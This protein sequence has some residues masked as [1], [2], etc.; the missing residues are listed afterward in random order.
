MSNEQPLPVDPAPVAPEE[1]TEPTPEELLESPED[2]VEVPEEQFVETPPALEEAGEETIVKEKTILEEAEGIEEPE[3]TQEEDTDPFTLENIQEQVTEKFDPAKEDFEER[4]FDID[5]EGVYPK[6]KE[7][8]PWHLKWNIHVGLLEAFADQGLIRSPFEQFAELRDRIPEEAYQYLD[9]QD[10]VILEGAFTLNDAARGG[11]KAGLENF[12]TGIDIFNYLTNKNLSTFDTDAMFGVP[13]DTLGAVAE[14]FG[15]F[16]TLFLPWMG[17]GRAVRGA[18]GLK[19]TL[20]SSIAIDAFASVMASSTGFDPEKGGVFTMVEQA[21]NNGTLP[22]SQFLTAAAQVFDS[23]QYEG[24]DRIKGRIALGFEDAL[25]TPFFELLRVPGAVIGKGKKFVASKEVR[26][27]TK[28]AIEQIRA[29]NARA[30]E[31]LQEN[32]NMSES[33]L[34][35]QLQMEGLG[36]NQIQDNYILPAFTK[37]ASEAFNIPTEQAEMIV[38]KFVGGGLDPERVFFGNGN[39]SPGAQQVMLNQ[40]TAGKRFRDED[41]FRD[42]AK[43]IDLSNANRKFGPGKLNPSIRE[44]INKLKLNKQDTAD[45]QQSVSSVLQ[46][47]PKGKDG[48]WE[49]LEVQSV[50]L[51]KDSKG[52]VKKNPKTGLPEVDV[53]FKQIPYTFNRDKSGKPFKIG[54]PEA[55]RRKKQLAKKMVAELKELKA[56]ANAGDQRAKDILNARTWYSGMEERL[57]REWGG[58]VD[59]FGEMLG[60]TSPQTPVAQ[61]Y[62]NAQQIIENFTK[63]RY[64]DVLSRYVA[65]LEN[66]G[67]HQTWID[68]GGEIIGKI[69]PK[70]GKPDIGPKELFAPQFDNN[71]KPIRKTVGDPGLYGTNTRNIMEVLA[72]KWWEGKFGKP[73]GAPKALTFAGNL[74]GYT[75][76]ATIDVWAARQLQRLSGKKMVPPPAEGAV[77]GQFLKSGKP[78]GAYGFASDVLDDAVE[79]LRK[80]GG[81]FEN[82]DPRDL[83]AIMW[84]Q[85]KAL[86]ADQGLGSLGGSMESLA[87]MFNAQRYVIGS[88]VARE[89]RP[90]GSR[91]ILSTGPDGKPMNFTITGQDR[92]LFEKAK[93]FVELEARNDDT[94]GAVSF[95][96]N[97][98]IF[99]LKGEDSFHLEVTTKNVVGR[100]E[101][102]DPATGKKRID[103]ATGKPVTKSVFQIE[104]RP[105]AGSVV[106]M[107]SYVG[108][109]GDQDAVMVSRVLPAGNLDETLEQVPNARPGLEMYFDK[110]V[111]VQEATVVLNRLKE[112]GLGAQTINEVSR[113]TTRAGSN[114][115]IGIRAVY[116]PEFDPMA[117]SFVGNKEGALAHVKGQ[118]ERFD[119]LAD[120]FDGYTVSEQGV[121]FNRVDVSAFDTKILG[122]EDYDR[123]LEEIN[124]GTPVRSVDREAWPQRSWHD[125]IEE[126]TGRSE[127]GAKQPGDGEISNPRSGSSPRELNQAASNADTPRGRAVLD[128]LS[129]VAFINGLEAA[130]VS[131][132]VHEF[133]HALNAQLIADD[134]VLAKELADFYGVKD[135]KWTDEAYERF[136]EDSE[137]FMSEAFEG[138]PGPLGEIAA[139]IRDIYVSSRGTPLEKR[140]KPEVKQFFENLL[141][142]NDLPIQYLPGKYMAPIS[143]TPL[144]K[145]VK[146]LEELGEDWRETITPDMIL[147]TAR[148]KKT[149][150]IN[151]ALDPDESQTLFNADDADDVHK[152][153]AAFEHF[154]VTLRKEKLMSN[155]FEDA[156]NKDA[157]DLYNMLLG[158]EDDQLH[159]TFAELMTT[160]ARVDGSG[161]ARTVAVNMAL[162]M[163]LEKVHRLALKAD[164]TGSIVDHAKLQRAFMDF[165]YVSHMVAMKKRSDGQSL[166]AWNQPVNMPTDEDLSDP[167]KALDFMNKLKLDPLSNQQIINFIKQGGDPKSHEGLKALRDASKIA[168]FGNKSQGQGRAATQEFF[169]N[170]LLSNPETALGISFLSPLLTLTLDGA[171]KFVGA[172]L[173]ADARTMNEVLV[174]LKQN[175]QNLHISMY[176]AMRTAKNEV[177][178]LMPGRELNDAN[179]DQRAIRMDAE[180]PLDPRHVVNGIGQVVRTPSRAIMTIDEL[181]RQTSARSAAYTKSYRD[182]VD[183]YI[184]VG[185][186]EGRIPMQLSR[187]GEMRYQNEIHRTAHQHALKETKEVIKDGRLQDQ[188]AIM[189]KVMNSPEAQALQDKPHE[190][191]LYIMQKTQEMYTPRQHELVEHAK[192]AAV[193]PVFQGDIGPNA[194]RFQKFLDNTSWGIGRLFVPFFRT[195]V[196]VMG[197]FLQY[198]PTALAESAFHTAATVATGGRRLAEGGRSFKLENSPLY[199]Y[200]TKHLERVNSADPVIRAEALGQQTVGLGLLMFNYDLYQ[201]GIIT[202]NGPN[203]PTERKILMQTGWQPYSVK[204]GDTYYSISRLDPYGMF[205]GM[206][207]D[208]FDL[209]ESEPDIPEDEQNNMFT[210]LLYTTMSQIEKMPML[211]GASDL[212]QA[213]GNPKREGMKWVKNTSSNFLVPFS[214]FQNALAK[215]NDPIVRETRSYWDAHAARTVYGDLTRKAPPKYSAIGEPYTRMTEA[216]AKRQ[217]EKGFVLKTFDLI[218]PIR[219]SQ[220]ADDIVWQGLASLEHSFRPP[221]ASYLGVDLTEFDGPEGYPFNAYTYMMEEVGKAKLD[222]GLNDSSGN[223]LGEMTLRETLTHAFTPG[224]PLNDQLE[225]LKLMPLEPNQ[226]TTPAAGLIQ[227]II[228]GYHMAGRMALLKNVPGIK[229]EIYTAERDVLEKQKALFESQGNLEMAKEASSQ[230]S[231][232]NEELK[233]LTEGV[234]NE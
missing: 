218:N 35:I 36:F 151:R 153:L 227:E 38:A 93:N 64:D 7:E 91:T 3:D 160:D 180:G 58:Y 175:I 176:Y 233:Q 131:T 24:N 42:N 125:Q 226:T 194:E 205:T 28:I 163:H 178:T 207:A 18:V 53:T 43:D 65:H 215:Y 186:Q 148:V 48:P 60:A 62:I 197:R 68:G 191:A 76:K 26:K 86:W 128:E 59:M 140:M 5:K 141:L 115:I 67:T 145:R 225:Q 167:A 2:S 106:R 22:R 83:Q 79:M 121:Q 124:A 19:N 103:P 165:Q 134:S 159:E 221:H 223:V 210:A 154:A 46:R 130:D 75:K 224:T 158:R 27:Q 144:V 77:G 90:L 119:D 171:S 96:E 200:H 185:Q 170:N 55:K 123:V 203:D 139:R 8:M 137:K 33:S 12:N 208:F 30:E 50:K 92:E 1:I 179:F 105:D 56:K 49:T 23:T 157:V 138:A 109:I 69:N 100:V 104:A 118:F 198:V 80:E 98:G 126:T 85:E 57:G 187:M 32:P 204:I 192:E 195:P 188:H 136:A 189:Q 88:S 217:K 142:R 39:I 51:I 84:F 34:L 190:R 132:A 74:I 206:V 164:K 173:G 152:M 15:Q 219:T 114:K 112:E 101:D 229:K 72:T 6:S 181:F 111:S 40:S 94:I 193:K 10:R 222:I 212:A 184:A 147:A 149:G 70:T 82:V 161:P 172:L 29:R 110:P 41:I 81:E 129:G 182:Y 44:S 127:G 37:L 87:S 234:T 211:Q 31:I 20:F 9:P 25:L 102:I 108:K 17:A 117:S 11:G 52:N 228:A 220:V 61:N 156:T 47:F 107:A 16:L 177:A 199:K 73:G 66:N 135:G 95:G 196:N 232:I 21:M 146:E 89:V 231:S 113:G 99:E 116:V 168:V 71:G 216:A 45:V 122:R 78:G 202:G 201:Q 143:W 155:S 166:R 54:S 213:V 14:G 174:N 162:S 133:S 63:G 150:K 13:E 97:L 169:V 183:N 4:T 120:V 209:L 230:L 214:S